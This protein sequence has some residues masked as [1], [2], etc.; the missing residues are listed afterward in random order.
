M[1]EREAVVAR[2]EGNQ[3]YVELLGEASGCGRCH[4]TGGCQ[5]G[6]L[7]QLF[8]ARPRQFCMDNPIAAAPGEHV[9][10]RVEEG[11]AL[12]AALL[13][14]VLPLALLLL[15]ALAGATLGE[16]GSRDAATAMGALAGLI[17]GVLAGL[18]FRK[19]RFARIAQP[20]LI[21][22]FHAFRT[23]REIQQ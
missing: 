13:V 14:Y 20:V 4:E 8:C 15:G 2:I 1:M 9:I 22:R 5:S 19:T 11:A 18:T 16:G 6:I 17:A 12:R 7:G 10:V 3:A 23:T 21:R